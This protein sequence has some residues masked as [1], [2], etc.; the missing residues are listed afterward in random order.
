MSRRRRR[1][2]RRGRKGRERRLSP[3]VWRNP[4]S[5]GGARERTL[6]IMGGRGGQGELEGAG[7]WASWPVSGERRM[8][9]GGKKSELSAERRRD[10]EGERGMLGKM[11]DG[12]ARR[13]ADSD[14]AGGGKA[15][16]RR[17]NG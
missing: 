13:G 17:N 16:T 8:R 12:D 4:G 5:E 6:K 3:A 14:V 1:K 15:G 2:K 11:R 10:G 9:R 7:T